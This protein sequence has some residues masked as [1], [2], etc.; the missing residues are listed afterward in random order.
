M[1]ML[2]ITNPNPQALARLNDIMQQ[3]GQAANET[4]ARHAF[5]DH[6]A[7][8]ADNT[9]RRKVA[10]LALFETFLNEYGI[11][12]AGLYDNPHAWRGITWGIVEAF[13]NWQLQQGYAIGIINGRLS[14]VRTFA[15]IV[16][17][18]PGRARRWNTDRDSL[19]KATEARQRAFCFGGHD[20]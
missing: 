20:R 2:Q 11:P 4:A 3:A 18:R 10:D 13:H 16:L 8:K 5:T 7:R 19:Q 17:E 15:K 6:T 1:K 9:I 14:T 12:A